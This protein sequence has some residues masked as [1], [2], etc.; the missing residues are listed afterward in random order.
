MTIRMELPFDEVVNVTAKGDVDLARQRSR[1]RV[2]Y[3]PGG[4]K[5]ELA[6]HDEV[7]DGDLTY[8]A[9]PGSAKWVRFPG[10][11]LGA[12]PC[13][14]VEALATAPSL[15]R[16]GEEVVRGSRTV[17]Y[18]AKPPGYFATVEV[19]VARD[20]LPLRLV[21]RVGANPV[22]KTVDLDGY[23]AA[24]AVTLPAR[25]VAVKDASAGLDAV[26]RP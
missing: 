6:D 1:V 14:I 7:A 24:P 12:R 21:A 3:D 23:G 16:V 25:Y 26:K 18:T 2:H 9:R 5:L 8:L 20:G 13:D 10:P 4:P 17:H 11:Y 15:T 19:W 22:T